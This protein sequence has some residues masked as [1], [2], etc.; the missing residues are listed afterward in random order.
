[1]SIRKRK[2]KDGYSYD[3]VVY[4]SGRKR[5]CKTVHSKAAA[6]ALEAQLTAERDAQSARDGSLTLKRYIYTMYWP[7]A[8]KRLSA[9]SCDTY[10]QEIRLRIVPSLGHL[11]LRDIDRAAIQS[12]MVDRCKNSGIARKSIG[13]GKPVPVPEGLFPG[14][15][16][17]QPE[18]LWGQGP[19]VH[20]WCSGRS[21]PVWAAW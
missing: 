3:V 20:L 6:V 19:A 11:A 9:T 10:E 1:M 12:L 16:F 5:K 8:V 13:V 4:T 7:V 15:Q 14:L 21:P 17:R 2:T 18:F